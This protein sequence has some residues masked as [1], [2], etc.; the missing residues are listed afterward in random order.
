MQQL[1]IPHREGQGSGAGTTHRAPVLRGG[2]WKECSALPWTPLRSPRDRVLGQHEW[3]QDWERRGSG[4]ISREESIGL[5][6]ASTGQGGG[7]EA[8]MAQGFDPGRSNQWWGPEVTGRWTHGGTAEGLGAWCWG[9][10]GQGAGPAQKTQL[11]GTPAAIYLEQVTVLH[12]FCQMKW[13]VE[14]YLTGTMGGFQP[15]R[16][17]WCLPWSASWTVTSSH[18]VVFHEVTIITA[19][20]YWW[21]A[22]CQAAS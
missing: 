1:L 21:P 20:I 12:L 15:L 18:L 22:R 19:S 8:K 7:G 10:K 4:N 11:P 6:D 9:E 17:V 3:Q 5:R 2:W 13:E 14:S 16:H